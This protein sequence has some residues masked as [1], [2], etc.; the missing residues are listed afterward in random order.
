MRG[1]PPKP[2]ALK[3]VAG[4]PGGRPIL[5]DTDLGADDL[6]A[7]A[8][9]LRDPTVDIRAI[10]IPRTGLVHCGP[11]LRTLRNLLADFGAPAV[12]LGCGHAGAEP[13]AYPFPESWREATVIA[14]TE[15]RP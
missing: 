7:L 8:V 5:V 11:G 14:D 15:S 12:P 2:S 13:E 9:L 10:T 1:R 4:N 3:L 6:T